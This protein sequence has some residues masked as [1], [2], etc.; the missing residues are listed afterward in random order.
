MKNRLKVMADYGCF[1]LWLPDEI[2]NIAPED[3]RLGLTTDLV[4]RLTAW[5]AEFDAILQWDD[6]ASSDFPS[7]QAEDEFA[8]TGADISRAVAKELGQDWAVTYF[9]LRSGREQVVPS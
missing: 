3:T 2:D 7:P 6:P 1:P 5:A 9:D 8:E 4:K